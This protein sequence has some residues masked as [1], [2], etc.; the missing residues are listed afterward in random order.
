MP[1]ISRRDLMQSLGVAGLMTAVPSWAA[2]PKHKKKLGIALLG[3]GYY[4]RDLL[5]PGLQLTQHCELKGIVTGSPHKIPIWQKKYGLLDKN[6]YS[7]EQLP[8][9]ANNPDIDVVYV[10]APTFL[11]AHFTN[12]IANAGKHVWCEKPMAMT[13]A[14]CQSM[15]DV[16]AKNKV[17][18]SIGY[19]LQHEPNTQ[20]IVDFAKSRPYGKI[21]QVTA[22]AGYA[23]HGAPAD[24]W[25]MDRSKGGGALYDMGVYPINA[26]RYSTGLEPKNV[27]ARFE[28]DLP[29]VFK[30]ADST[31]ILTL[32]FAEGLMAELHT[33]V[34]RDF[35][36]LQVQCEKGGYELSPMQSYTGVQGIT[37]DGKKLN[38]TVVHQQAKQMDDDALANLLKKP[39]LVPGENGLGDIRVVEAALRSIQ[40]KTQVVI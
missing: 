4:S 30:K 40:A 19:R 35:N 21:I 11:H 25:R 8:A 6:M 36:R 27:L 20:T 5:A 32:E 3:L 39:V 9:I 22:K 29:D 18:L 1:N 23:G 14:E 26:A 10:V 31:A 13:V 34:V 38:K 2:K 33:S 16:C 37:S 7:Y 17:T 24:D 15:I 12:I 28:E